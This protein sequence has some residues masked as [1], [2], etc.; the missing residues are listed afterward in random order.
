MKCN[1]KLCG[2]YVTLIL[3][4]LSA[5]PTQSQSQT[6][7][8]SQAASQNATQARIQSINVWVDPRIE[9]LSVVQYLSDYG[10]RFRLLTDHDFTYKRDIE[11]RFAEYRDHEAVHLFTEMSDE[12][13]TYDAPPGAM[14]LLK[15]VP[16][17]EPLHDFTGYLCNRAG[18]KERLTRL[19]ESLR[20]FAEETRFMDF[21]DEQ[22]TFYRSL[23]DDVRVHL[24]NTDYVKTLEK[25][26]GMYENDYF[27]ILAPMFVGNYGP[28]M[29]NK[30]GTYDI[31]C[32]M[33][34]KGVHED[35]PHF[36]TTETFR[37][38]AWH[39]WGH[40]FINPLTMWYKLDLAKCES[41]YEPIAEKMKRRAYGTWETC[42]NEHIVR[43]LTTRLTY[44][45]INES[46][47]AEALLYEKGRGF[48][49][50]EALCESLEVYEKQRDQYPSLMHYYPELMKVL[51][52]LA[53][54]DLG[55]E[56]YAVPFTGTVGSAMSD[57]ES[58][59]CILPTQ[60]EDKETQEKLHDYVRT[61]HQRFFPDAPLI[62][63]EEAMEKD[64]SK[65]TVVL[66]GTPKGNLWLEKVISDMP[67]RIE[68]DR[69]V[70]TDTYEGDDLR[71]I[72]S[73]PNPENPQRPV[74]IYTAQKTEDVI[75]ING[76]VH[77]ATDFLVARGKLVLACDNYIKNKRKWSFPE[78][79]N[80]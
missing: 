53:A 58:I 46:E 28:T 73:W 33:G 23:I 1:A 22:S 72:S 63:D 42:V 66:Y 65:N 11:K 39:E 60:E 36:G 27:I 37:H 19:V 10:G 69:I 9:L 41:L 26:C 51:C 13:F 49:Y 4:A 70:A 31:Y 48:A 24:E 75:G 78:G 67:V 16:T 54:Q 71:F 74:V 35:R 79:L 59:I 30:K 76:V 68:P 40:S 7:T 62:T 8:Q 15:G 57:R 56:F 43:A 80:Q 21:F 18:G 12:G 45:E 61:I 25:Y 34:S 32:I 17:L 64:L 2:V 20:D 47:G 77:G 6:V 38:L 52:D 3:M 14:L 50:V 5:A 29:G 44:R 55:E